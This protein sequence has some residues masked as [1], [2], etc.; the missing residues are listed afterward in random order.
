M[1][2][3]AT[4]S[5]RPADVPALARLHRTA[6]PGF[7]LSNLG[8]PFLREFYRGFLGD[9]TAVTVVMR[10]D[11]GI[12]VGCAVGTTEPTGFFSR[13]LRR[14]WLGFILASIRATLRRPSAIVRL[15]RAIA[16]RGAKGAGEGALLSS[17]CVAP[18]ARGAGPNLLAGWEARA[19]RLGARRAYLTTDAYDNETVNRFYAR[20]GWVVAERFET[21]EGRCMHRYTK[22]LERV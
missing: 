19:S 1:E 16:Y 18:E 20:N 17:I 7:F 22:E 2:S 6:F 15:A 5:L 12:I 4:A 13:L 3:P 8:E 14:R 10:N 21:R 11:T 9:P